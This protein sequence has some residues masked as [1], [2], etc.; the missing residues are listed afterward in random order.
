MMST[1]LFRVAALGLWC[2]LPFAS[3]AQG[4]GDDA[5]SQYA[6]AG[7]RALAT[8]QYATA[9]TDFE[10]LAG[11]EPGIA[12]VHATLA[13]IYYKQR[14]YDLAVREIRTAQKLKPSLPKLDS[15][16][17]MSLAE[18]GRFTD[19][20]PG[21]EKG[22]KQ[23]ADA[24]IERM[25]G[26]QLL[27]AYTGLGRD[28]DAVET[29]LTLNKKF[30]NDPE[31]LYQTGRIYGNFAYLVML[32][33]NDKAPGS[34]WVLQ[35]AGEAH[36]S[37]KAYDQAIAEFKQVLALDPKRP[38]IHYR[39]GRVLL[40]RWHERQTTPD[41]AAAKEEFTLELQIDPANSNA[42]YEIGE[43][44]RKA[45]DLVDAQSMFEAAIKYHSDFQ[46]AQV[47]LADVLAS[48]SMWKDALPHLERA[49]SLRP[50]DQV[51]WY[52]LSQVDRS[53]GDSA[54]QRKA[55]AEFQ[56]LRNQNQQDRAAAPREVTQQMLDPGA[57]P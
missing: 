4:G 51:A 44:D 42:A 3:L 7:Q 27:R 10:K 49:V 48:Q 19:A 38:G 12:E 33:L 2:C 52:R 8:G 26:L 22:F 43:I 55:L 36:E 1:R 56:K 15:L 34:I 37:Q 46:E 16:M 31:I 40:D 30:P 53:L 21:L 11:L 41:I 13:V 45:G 50:D 25:C 29:S 5:A 39:I 57:N 6:A 9:Q 18:L 35:A 24:E 20:L 32:R 54:G 14:E 17:G 47:G 23:T 28:S